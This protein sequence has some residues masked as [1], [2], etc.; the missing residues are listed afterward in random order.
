MGR[1]AFL[2]LELDKDAGADS[3][4]SF[5]LKSHQAGKNRVAKALDWR[6]CAQAYS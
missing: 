3:F 2:E 6:H 1:K 4:V 5:A